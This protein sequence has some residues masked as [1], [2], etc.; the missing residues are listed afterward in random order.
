MRTPDYWTSD[1]AEVLLPDDKNGYK[2][3]HL[4]GRKKKD[5]IDKDKAKGNLEERLDAGRC[6]SDVC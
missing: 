4:T 6:R 1:A 2:K 3:M 5:C